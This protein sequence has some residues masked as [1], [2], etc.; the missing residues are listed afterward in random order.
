LHYVETTACCQ[1]ISA[2]DRNHCG[3]LALITVTRLSHRRLPGAGTAG[4]EA[5]MGEDGLKSPGDMVA[6][7]LLLALVL[8]APVLF[9]V[10]MALGS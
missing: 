2:G 9:D 6:V 10:A 8:L 4:D 1:E 5:M 3:D 7:V